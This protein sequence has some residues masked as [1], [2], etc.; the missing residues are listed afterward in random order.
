MEPER[1][2]N[3]TQVYICTSYEFVYGTSLN[4]QRVH[5]ITALSIKKLE[6]ASWRWVCWLLWSVWWM[7]CYVWSYRV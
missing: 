5:L 6:L 7:L 2:R 4:V 1:L 3:T